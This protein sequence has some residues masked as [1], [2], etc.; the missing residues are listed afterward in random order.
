MEEVLFYFEK[1]ASFA[2]LISLF[3][4]IVISVV[5]VIPSFFLTA[6][7]ILFFGFWYGTLVSFLGEALGAVVSFIIYRKGFGKLSKKIP[8]EKY[9]RVKRLLEVEKSEAFYLILGL[10]LFPFV[11]SGIVNIFAALGKVSLLLFTI[12]S[13]VGK[14]PAL[15]MEAYSVLQ[16][17]NFTW[18]GKVIL[19]VISIYFFIIIYKKIKQSQREKVAP[20]ENDDH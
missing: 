2:I 1:Y 17:S 20:R 13:S 15:L 14:I 11:P 18:Q 5:G 3:I 7:N 19:T 16:I 10:R 9:P 12:A 8:S 6:A 4:N